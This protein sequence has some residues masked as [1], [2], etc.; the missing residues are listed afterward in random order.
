MRNSLVTR[1]YTRRY[2]IHVGED[3]FGNQYYRNPKAHRAPGLL[4]SSEKRW[5][6]YNG[7]PEASR[8]PPAWHAWL[9]HITD[10]PPTSVGKGAHAQPHDD[11]G[12]VPPAGAHAAR[13]QARERHRRLRA[14]AAV[15]T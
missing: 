11:G 2:G 15:L 14:V 7:A 3:Q 8:V 9:H 4:S 5:V 10:E 6:L 12:G 13:G 1:L